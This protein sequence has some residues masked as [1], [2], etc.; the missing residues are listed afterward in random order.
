V[1]HPVIYRAVEQSFFNDPSV[2]TL[3]RPSLPSRRLGILRA[4][5]G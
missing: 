1:V 4:G 3:F 2:F 5:G